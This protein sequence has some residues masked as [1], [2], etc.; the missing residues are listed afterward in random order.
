MDIYFQS[1]RG[2]ADR[3][4]LQA[5]YAQAQNMSFTDLALEV[6]AAD[7]MMYWG[8]HAMDMYTIF[9]NR[10]ILDIPDIGV[11]QEQSTQVVV[12]NSSGF[13]NGESLTVHF[14]SR[15]IKTYSLSDMQGRV[16]RKGQFS[17]REWSLS[18]AGLSAGIY[19]LSI[20]CSEGKSNVFRLI[21]Y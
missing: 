8:Q 1:G 4:L 11:D 21:R 20:R 6:L 7:S 16:V 12:Y 14:D 5:L 19:T 13:A 17:M 2:V 10:G 9:E 3:V 18:G 15:G